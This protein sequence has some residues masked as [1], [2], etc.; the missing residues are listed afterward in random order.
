MGKSQ[1]GENLGTETVSDGGD[2]QNNPDELSSEPGF[3]FDQILK[4]VDQFIETLDSGENNFTCIDQFL[5][6]VDSEI[7]AYELRKASAKFGLNME[8]F[9][10]AVKLLWT[11]IRRLEELPSDSGATSCLNRAGSEHHR[12]MLLLENEF[13]TLLDI[14]TDRNEGE[15]KLKTVEEFPY[16]SPESVSIMNRIGSTMIFAGYEAE[17]CIAYSGLRLK[18]LD[19]ELSKLSFENINVDDAERM[20][21]ESLEVEIG[22]WLHIMK[23]CTN[24]LFSEERTLCN[25]VFSEHPSI[26][27]RL[28]C[29]LST[30]LTMRLLNFPNALVLPRQYSTEKLFKFLDIYEALRD[31]N[32]MEIG[33]YLSAKEFMSDTFTVQCRIG[34]TAVSIFSQLENSIE[35]DNAGRIPVAGG[36]VHPLTRYTMNYLKYACE[37]KDTLEQVFQKHNEMEGLTVQKVQENYIEKDDRFLPASPFALKLVEVMDLLD[38]NIEMKSKLYRSPSLRYIFLMNNGR[39]ILQKL[40][41]STDIYDMLG[42]SWSRKRTSELRQYHK[43]YQRDTWSNVLQTISHEGVQVNGKVSKPILKERFKNFNALFEEI[44]KT[45]STWVVS[46]GQLKSELRVSISSV[47]IPAYRSFVGRFQSYF[48]NSKQAGKYIK[49]QPEDIEELIEQLFEGNTTSM[50]RRS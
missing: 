11:I 45:Q 10:E 21:W 17:C 2:E 39:Y 25:S 26:A 38:A 6:M 27:Q 23:H 8:E 33:N 24:N 9:F 37:Y 7:A 30:S 12:A 50:I 28:F 40:K 42:H 15:T 20:S 49:Y 44:L 18:A 19:A 29:E 3:K 35:S 22:N 1:N 4:D 41:E 43:L 31:L 48:D 14:N 47:M 46:D 5:E 16:F 13:R 34:E 32:N 36:A